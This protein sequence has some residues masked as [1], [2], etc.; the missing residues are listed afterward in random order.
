M[1]GG[2]EESGSYGITWVPGVM[3]STERSRMLVWYA[4]K[5]KAVIR[6]SSSFN[7]SLV[8]SSVTLKAP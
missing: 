3:L 6:K 1:G 7:Y 8:Y 2:Q 4:Y 5:S